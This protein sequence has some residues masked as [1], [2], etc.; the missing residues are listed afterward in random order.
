MSRINNT[1]RDFLKAAGLTVAATTVGGCLDGGIGGIGIGVEKIEL[2]DEPRPVSVPYHQPNILWISC[3]DM[4]PHLGCYGDPNAITPRLDKLAADGVRYTNAFVVAGVCAPTRCSIITGMYPTTLGT[5]HMRSG[6]SGPDRSVKPKMPSYIR[7]FSEYLRH[8][9]YYCTNNSKQDY[10]F[11]PAKFSWD[12]SSTKAHWRNR[13]KQDAPFFAVFNYTGTHEGSFR[14][15]PEGHA[16]RT[17][18]LSARERQAP[19][20]LTPPPYYPDTPVVREQWARYYELITAMDYWA[21][22][23]LDQLERDGLAEDTIVF[24]WSDHGVGMPRAKRWLYD[25]GTHIPLIVRIPEKFRVASQGIAG[26]VDDQ[27]ISSVDFAPTVLNLSQ[28]TIPEHMQG[29]AFLGTSLPAK[30]RYVFGTRDR[31]DERYDII[32][33]VRD[34]QFR[35]I[36]NYEPFKPYLQYIAYAERGLVIQEIRQ[37]AKADTLPA[38]AKL[39]MS[40]TKPTEELYDLQNDPHEINNLAG[41]SSYESV[42]RRM[43]RA[44]V[45]WMIETND[46]GLV[47]EPELVAGEQRLG[48]RYEIFHQEPDE[49]KR[50]RLLYIAALAGAP[51]VNDLSKLTDAIRDHDPAVRYWAA[52]GLGNLGMDARPA[53]SFIYMALE[54]DS[55][56]VRIATARAVCKMN[57][58]DR[59]LALLVRELKSP[60]EWVRLYAATALDELGEK[61]RPAIDDLKQALNDR[62]NKYVVNVVKQTLKRLAGNK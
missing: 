7:C 5:H 24:F 16:T 40:A 28:V 61:A 6:G 53:M 26:V 55:P 8:D 45:E 22:D 44:H 10:N 41:N 48:T 37:A 57:M 2:P 27:L 9:G 32:R 1:R 56:V 46:L 15:G 43:R 60:Q 62:H 49:R 3:E 33:S 4:G 59:G 30:R 31:M 52:I 23:L 38:A 39:F 14:L 29:R 12:E 58:L 36:R 13:P 19:E 21:G 17:K 35:Y 50:L 25:S 51:T 18:R 54:D 11:V 47:P 34:K 20:K 42:L